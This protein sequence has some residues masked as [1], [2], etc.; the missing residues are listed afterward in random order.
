MNLVTGQAH[1][2][3]RHASLLP[4]PDAK[5]RVG[6]RDNLF[7]GKP[8]PFRGKASTLSMPYFKAFAMRFD[9]LLERPLQLVSSSEVR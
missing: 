6:G 5:L 3:G 1:R 8:S 9:E 7:G 4:E 2:F